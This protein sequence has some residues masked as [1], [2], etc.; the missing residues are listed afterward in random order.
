M[1]NAVFGKTMEHPRNRV[2]VKLVTD[3]TQLSKL[4]SKLTF[5]SSTNIQRESGSSTQDQEITH[6]Q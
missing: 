1:N 3:E 5:V 6:S 4:T 2:D